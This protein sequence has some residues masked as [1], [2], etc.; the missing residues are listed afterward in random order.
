MSHDPTPQS[1]QL[2]VEEKIERA[3]GVTNVLLIPRS[4]YSGKPREYKPGLTGWHKLL[5]DSECLLEYATESGIELDPHIVKTIIS[6]GGESAASD[7]DAVKAMTAMTTLAAKLKPV[8]ADTLRACKYQAQTTMRWYWRYVIIIALIIVPGSIWSFFATGLSNA[9]TAE[10]THANQLVVTVNS[11]NPP[12]S[13][14]GGPL[15]PTPVLTNLQQFAAATREIYGLAGQLSYFVFASAEGD[16]DVAARELEIKVPLS[17]VPGEAIAKTVT[18]Q[19][20]RS[21]ANDILRRTALANGALTNCILPLLYALL[22]ACAYLLKTVSDQ[23]KTRTF[24]PPATDTAR[25]TMAAIGGEIV[26]LFSGFTLGPGTSLSPLGLAF[27]IG[28]GTEIFF[29]FLD[30]LEQAFLK[31]KTAPAS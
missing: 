14:G 12:Q 26:G 28:Y 19:K 29:S 4:F 30:S 23:V 31:T 24:L 27:L 22:G 13:N 2:T 18:F 6:A 15:P 25:F 20:A 21:Y 17:D 16:I 11:E 8:T 5:D 10:I 3:I 9:L 7:N 1:G